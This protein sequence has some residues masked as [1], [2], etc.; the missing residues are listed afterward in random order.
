MFP[1]F[2]PWVREDHVQEAIRRLGQLTEQT[3]TEVIQSVPP[4]WAVDLK[5]RGAWKEL[6]CRRAG[7]VAESV[8]SKIAKVC[9]PGQF[10]DT[11][12]KNKVEP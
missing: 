12:P 10:F 11:G 9:W 8:L 4:E 1:A 7:F 3:V 5:T 6:I 2:V